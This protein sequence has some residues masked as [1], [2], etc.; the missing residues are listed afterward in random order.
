MCFV[1]P[2]VCIGGN[3]GN[4]Y[5]V[6]SSERGYGMSMYHTTMALWRYIYGG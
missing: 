3:M 2:G 4:K 1:L 5:V 6:Y